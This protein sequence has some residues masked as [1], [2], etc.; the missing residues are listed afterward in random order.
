MLLGKRSVIITKF[1][2]PVTWF[3]VFLY[4]LFSLLIIAWDGN[5]MDLMD[6]HM[7]VVVVVAAVMVIPKISMSALPSSTLWETFYRVLGSSVLPL[8]FILYQHGD[9]P[10]QFA[11][12][13][14][15]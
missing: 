7:V 2:Y 14:S 10:I 15:Q 1:P 3:D 12:L 4:F 9:W 11:H 8:S 6:I 5:Y 13:S